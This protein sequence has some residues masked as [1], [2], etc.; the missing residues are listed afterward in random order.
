MVGFGI[1]P[2]IAGVSANVPAIA[3]GS[4]VDFANPKACFNA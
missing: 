4:A 1:A 3:V 2:A